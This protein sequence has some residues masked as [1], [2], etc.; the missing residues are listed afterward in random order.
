[1]RNTRCILTRVPT[2]TTPSPLHGH[3]PGQIPTDRPYRS[4]AR[5]NQLPP[6]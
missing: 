6:P 1:M 5:S 4:I 2:G 3:G